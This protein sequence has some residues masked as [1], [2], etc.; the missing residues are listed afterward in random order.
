MQLPICVYEITGSAPN[1]NLLYVH[2][3]SYHIST[4]LV[5][6]LFL[7]LNLTFTYEDNNESLCHHQIL[8]IRMYMY[9]NTYCDID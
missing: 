4:Q 2:I 9:F 8:Y 1:L 5:I 6:Q 7:V 3:Y